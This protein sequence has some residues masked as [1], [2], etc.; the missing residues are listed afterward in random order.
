MA[1][2]GHIELDRSV[3]SIRVGQRHRTELGDL[4]ELVASIDRLGLLQPITISPDGTLICG[5]RRLEAVKRLGWQRVNV[6][7]RSGISTRLEQLLAE[8]HEN[9]M[10]K[11]FTPTEAA[12]LYQELKTLI[13]EDATRRQ[14]A[15]RF[16]ANDGEE[17]AEHGAADS[18]APSD[19]TSRVQAAQLVTGR[20]SY[21]MLEQVSELERIAADPETPEHVRD[22]A[23]EELANIDATGKVYGSYQRV[24]TAL[25][26]GAAE[27]DED[28]LRQDELA[29]RAKEALAR[30]QGEP[31]RHRRAKTA[32]AR[33]SGRG[34][35][36]YGV[37]AFVVTWSDLHGWA[38]HYDP[39]EIGP[40]LNAE[41]WASFEATV[42]ATVT[43]VD[44]ARLARD[45]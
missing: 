9:T 12:T 30:V 26:Q 1:S 35:R 42:E 2:G 28:E 17:G 38:D 36:R 7:V 5:A 21:S 6:W 15:S 43:F 37:R 32:T 8:Q 16:G 27:G 18:A 23:V 29:A 3:E 10:R 34:S 19:R 20:K 45:T 31:R 11:A 40:A 4:D 44:A 13:A 39:A 33:D 24:K 25:G 22:L 14:A 41:Q